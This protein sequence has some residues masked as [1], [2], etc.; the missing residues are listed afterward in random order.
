MPFIGEDGSADPMRSRWFSHEVRQADWPWVF[1]KG[2]K[3]LL[4]ISTLEALAVLMALNLF[5]RPP[6]VQQRTA[7]RVVP[8]WT[9]NRGNCAALNRLMTT[10]FPAS[11]VIME[12]AAFM[13]K[14]ALKAQVEWS[15]RSGNG[16]AD[17]LA[18]GSLHGFDPALRC[19]V[20]PSELEW[21]I[22]PKAFEQGAI[23][24]HE[25]RT[26]KERSQLPDWAVKQGSANLRSA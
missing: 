19:E 25:S 20:V 17:S 13:K 11:A 1:S 22:L 21:K 15:L 6:T 3:P 4:V 18:N 7:T 5:H 12:M 2:G 9:D 26:A 14:A 23:L 24:E 10:R 8:T 16:E